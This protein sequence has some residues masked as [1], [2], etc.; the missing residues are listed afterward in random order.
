ME[1]PIVV[2]GEEVIDKAT[3]QKG[4]LTLAVIN[5]DHR[6][7]YAFQPAKLNKQTGTPAKTYWVSE[8]QLE[9]YFKEDTEFPLNLLGSEVQDECTGYKGVATELVLHI[10]GCI[11]VYIQSKE[12]IP[13]TGET[14]NPIELDIRRLKGAELKTL[15]RSEL[16]E[17]RKQKPS[18]EPLPAR[19]PC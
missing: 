18:P 7:N 17:S 10:N 13:E 8:A 1:L 16:K 15:S 4:I 5:M 3:D 9:G 2:L 6:V 14:A 19:R 12:P 11:H